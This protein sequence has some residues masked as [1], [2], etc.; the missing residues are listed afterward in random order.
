MGTVLLAACAADVTAGAD[1]GTAT[2]GEA[3]GVQR[4]SNERLR[5]AASS[6]SQGET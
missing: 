5:L 6:R 1:T 3:T 4:A 2:K